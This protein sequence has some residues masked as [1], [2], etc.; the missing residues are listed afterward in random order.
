[1]YDQNLKSLFLERRIPVKLQSK[2]AE[3]HHHAQMSQVSVYGAKVNYG[4]CV[5]VF[6]RFFWGGGGAILR[7]NL[8]TE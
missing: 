5:F 8:V 7:R 1:M 2:G 4:F 3:S 6:V